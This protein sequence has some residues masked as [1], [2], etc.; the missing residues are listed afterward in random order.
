MNMDLAYLRIQGKSELSAAQLNNRLLTGE[1][2]GR[3]E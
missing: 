3:H 1:T 2:G